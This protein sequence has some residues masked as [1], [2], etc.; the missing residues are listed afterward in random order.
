VDGKAVV[1]AIAAESEKDF[2]AHAERQAYRA[3]A[4][5]SEWKALAAAYLQQYEL[6]Q[7]RLET[8]LYLKEDRLVERVVVE[9]TR[10]GA[11]ES[12]A[13]LVAS[14]W[15]VEEEVKPQS[16]QGKNRY[17]LGV[18][19][20]R[21]D[22]LWRNTV[23]LLDAA[24]ASTR[25]DRM[26]LFLLG[27]LYSGH[28]H[29]E[30]RE[31]TLLSP[32][33]SILWL[34]PR[35]TSGIDYLLKHVSKLEVVCKVGNHSRITFKQHLSNPEQHSL[36]WLLYHWLA[37]HYQ[38]EKR[39]RFHLT[40][41]Y[42]TFI[43]ILGVKVRAHHGDAFRYQGGIGGL[44]VPMNLA[45]SRWNQAEVA[46][47]DVMGHWHS[48]FPGRALVNGSLIGYSPLSVRFRSGFEPPQQ[49]FFIISGKHR[50]VTQHSPVFVE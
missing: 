37:N 38:A 26:V 47:Q 1:K 6:C 24:R 15:H 36:E 21:L 9:P 18:A 4:S 43:D 32:V 45:L 20:Q 17:N 30:L 19:E 42:H 11:S 31:T 12:V 50:R 3:R 8:M 23:S 10:S 14:D 35:I 34:K 49:A 7:T 44:L 13:C 39:L 41:S 28:I 25:I 22:H 46:D 33:E 2:R 48:Y 16:V 29:E 27:D 40:P 5:A